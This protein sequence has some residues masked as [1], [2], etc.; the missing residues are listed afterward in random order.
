M[1]L[2]LRYLAVALILLLVIPSSLALTNPRSWDK[3]G[4]LYY[5]DV[6][7]NIVP[8]KTVLSPTKAVMEIGYTEGKYSDDIFKHIAQLVT[9]VPKDE[10]QTAVLVND[11][12]V[13][14]IPP[15]SK[16]IGV[17]AHEYCVVIYQYGTDQW[18]DCEI[19]QASVVPKPT[20][21]PTVKATVGPVEVGEGL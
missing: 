10:I 20:V 6:P 16:F 11:K 18:Y 2:N 15:T 5:R 12:I 19:K 13:A 3:S 8:A 14:V 17:T 21:K 7:V 9:V 1:T 4:N